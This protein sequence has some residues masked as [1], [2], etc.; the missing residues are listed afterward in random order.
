MEFGQLVRLWQATSN[1]HKFNPPASQDDLSKVETGLA[2]HL[3]QA[4]REL[5]LFSNGMS[6]FEGCLRIYPLLSTGEKDGLESA[7]SQCRKWFQI[8]AEIV[9]FGDNGSDEHYGFWKTKPAN[10]TFACP[11]IE[12]GEL[13]HDPAC[14][15]F[16]ATNLLTF[17]Y[18]EMAVFSLLSE[19]DNEALYIIGLPE[20]LRVPRSQV[21]NKHFA[22]IRK[23]L[24][25]MLPDH[26]P[27]PYTKGLNTAQIRKILGV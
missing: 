6:L 20:A 21:N 10:E 4:L 27:E 13:F 25:P 5:Y 1:L 23:W 9:V 2:F 24:D 18:G 16:V 8:P 19:F 22:S 14:M 11:I 15:S 17:L 26:D 3:P 7:T 12:I